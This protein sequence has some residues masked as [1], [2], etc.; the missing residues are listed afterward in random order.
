MGTFD[1][2]NPL[3]SFERREEGSIIFLEI[4]LYNTTFENLLP[5]ENFST[6]GTCL[7][8]LEARTHLNI[9]GQTQRTNLFVDLRGC[10]SHM[11][12]EI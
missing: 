11:Y 2:C 1:I 5:L 10:L 3:G 7:V 8:C 9:F 12:L 6:T 4:F